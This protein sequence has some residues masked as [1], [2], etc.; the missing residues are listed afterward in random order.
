MNGKSS[1]TSGRQGDI[2]I[3]LFATKVLVK[4]ARHCVRQISDLIRRPRANSGRKGKAMLLLNAFSFNMLSSLTAQ[5]AVR[6][7]EIEEARRL[8]DGTLQ[9]AVGHANTADVFASELG[10]DVPAQRVNVEL[11]AGSRAVVG[12]YR[13]PRLAEGATELPEDATIVWLL[14]EI[15]EGFG[16]SEAGI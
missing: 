3:R 12:Q 6:E 15:R 11:S 10:F 2:W 7:I 4:S 9:S 13:G 14:L 5:I 8:L 1:R 16:V